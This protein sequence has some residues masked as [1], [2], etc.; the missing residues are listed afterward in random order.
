MTYV[1]ILRKDDLKKM[2]RLV[3]DIVKRCDVDDLKY[4]FLDS[5]GIRGTDRYRCGKYKN[6]TFEKTI[7]I[8]ISVISAIKSSGA[9]TAELALIEESG[10]EYILINLMTQKNESLFAIKFKKPLVQHPDF[11]RVEK[12]KDNMMDA[13]ECGTKELKETLTEINKISK[14]CIFEMWVRG[15]RLRA[16]NSESMKDIKLIAMPT[17]KSTR[18]FKIALSP[19]YLLDYLNKHKSLT[20]K[21]NFYNSLTYVWIE[22]YKDS[23]DYILMPLAL[24]E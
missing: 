8:P 24:I 19:K 1:R 18:P 20:V 11:Q 22:E 10:Q 15:G 6:I 4:L 5:D 7:A 12:I 2:Y 21:I 16:V 17:T 13:F 9:E 14:E 23:Y 3:A